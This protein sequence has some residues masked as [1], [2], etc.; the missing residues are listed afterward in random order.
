MRPSPLDVIGC[1][2]SVA[3]LTF[4]LSCFYFQVCLKLLKVQDFQVIHQL[5]IS[6]EKPISP[7]LLNLPLSLATSSLPIWEL[8]H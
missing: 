5:H 8:G 2:A 3:I 7:V 6:Q 1:P 4:G